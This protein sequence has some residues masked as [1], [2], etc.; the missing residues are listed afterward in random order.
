MKTKYYILRRKGIKNITLRAREV[1][2]L[3]LLFPSVATKDFFFFNSRKYIQML[4]FL[5]WRRQVIH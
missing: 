1:N 2:K 5:H 4:G 3:E